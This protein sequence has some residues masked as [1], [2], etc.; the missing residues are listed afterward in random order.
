MLPFEQGFSNCLKDKYSSQSVSGFHVFES[1][2]F[3]FFFFFLTGAVENSIYS[4]HFQVL[5]TCS[6]LA[7]T[8]FEM[9]V[10]KKLSPSTLWLCDVES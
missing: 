2:I 7:F 10:Y 1:N 6:L 4:S 3:L 8:H 5:Y 9:I